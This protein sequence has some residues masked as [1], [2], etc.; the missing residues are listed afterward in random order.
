M[1]SAISVTLPQGLK[2]SI[3]PDTTATPMVENA[4]VGARTVGTSLP[5]GIINSTDTVMPP[6]IVIADDMTSTATINL[7]IGV[8]PLT[9]DADQDANGKRLLAME[10]WNLADSTDSITIAPGSADPY[11]FLGSGNDITINPGMRLTIDCR[12]DDGVA[13]ANRPVAVSATVKN[14]DVTIAGTSTL[15]YVFVLGD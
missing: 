10:L 14:I 6:T 15:R 5:S 12:Q 3:S 13:P 1:A 4:S 8:D 2:A 11:P 9:G 7:R